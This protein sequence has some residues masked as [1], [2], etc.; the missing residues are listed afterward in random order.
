MRR[1]IELL[2]QMND[3]VLQ[4]L[5]VEVIKHLASEWVLLIMQQIGLI[6]TLHICD[7]LQVVGIVVALRRDL[8]LIILAIHVILTHIFKVMRSKLIQ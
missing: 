2:L 5:V 7:T 1:V 3:L 8:T 4:L 6:L